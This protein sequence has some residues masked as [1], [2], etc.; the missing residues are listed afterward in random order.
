MILVK[1]KV[2]ILFRRLFVALVL[3][4][5]LG[6]SQS[7]LGAKPVYAN[8]QQI[9]AVVNE[10]AISDSDLEK[11]L[12]L[13]MASSGIPNKAEIRKKLVP[14]VLDGLINEAL[15][16]QEAV[17][18]GI[19]VDPKEID[20][21][22]AQVAAQN[23]LK[24]EQFLGMLKRGGID[25]TTMRKQI[26]AQLAWSKVVQAKLRPRVTISER[27]IDDALER[28]KAKVGTTEYLAAE[29]F[30]PVEQPE[31][32][33]RVKKLANDLVYQ[34]KT[35]KAAF[36][37]L[38][39]QFSQAAGS[40]N[41]GDKGWVNEAQLPEELLKGLGSIK[42]NQITDPI[43]TLDGYHIMF[44]RDKRALTEENIPSRQQVQYNLGTERL[45]KLQRRH[46]MDLR[47]AS[48][49]DIRV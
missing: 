41:G 4:S 47:S 2:K 35:G 13:I 26:E 46:L 37:K 48:F 17:K 45:G 31:N 16:M 19:K 42:K 21:G 20:G 23:N 8:T 36:F 44:L 39:Q 7:Y 27:D 32:Q 30:L 28:I 24:P 40:T 49:V 25:V 5:L 3:C 11:R 15:M 9:V 10:D 29:I 33:T 12:R 6:T 14:Q 43:K 1:G 34:I 18:L 22:I 38:A